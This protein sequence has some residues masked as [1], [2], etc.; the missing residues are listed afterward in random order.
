MYFL[1]VYLFFC[2]QENDNPDNNQDNQN[3]NCN[4][5]R[6]HFPSMSSVIRAFAVGPHMGRALTD[7]NI[8][9]SVFHRCPPEPSILHKVLYLNFWDLFGFT[10]IH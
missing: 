9:F 3:D 7:I 8:N 5:Q 6:A 1:Y 10:L 2:H 4:E